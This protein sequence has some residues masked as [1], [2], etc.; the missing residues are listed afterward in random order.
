[1]VRSYASEPT[2]TRKSDAKARAAAL[3]VEMGAVDFILHGNKDSSKARSKIVLAPIDSR[4]I[5][6][7]GKV[8]EEEKD[9]LELGDDEASKQIK[10]CCIEWRAGLV[11]PRWVIY[12]E[13]KGSASRS[14]Y[15]SSMNGFY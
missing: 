15:S 7:E 1:M 14:F 6:E 12:L 5:K 8:K 3:A 9:T 13:H 2:F 10:D 11:K 4:M